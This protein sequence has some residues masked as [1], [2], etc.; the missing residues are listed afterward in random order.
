MKELRNRRAILSSIA[1]PKKGRA[2]QEKAAQVERLS[3]RSFEYS[4]ITRRLRL[5]GAYGGQPEP[6][7]R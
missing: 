3:L 5:C 2:A 6:V 1:L 7:D 4:E